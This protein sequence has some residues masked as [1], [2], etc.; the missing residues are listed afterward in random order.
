MSN[1]TFNQEDKKP[2][3]Y[4]KEV[5]AAKK[6]DKSSTDSL[7][8]SLRSDML[9]TSSTSPAEKSVIQR[10]NLKYV[11]GILLT[12][13][14]IV[15]VWFL[16]GGPGR[17]ILEHNLVLLVHTDT[18]PTQTVAPVAITPTAMP[19]Q[20][21]KSPFPSPTIRPTNTPTVRIVAS[22]TNPPATL[23]PTSS[24]ACRDALTISLADVGQTFCVQ[25][26]V[27]Q[28]IEAPNGFMVIFDN[29]PGSFYWVAYDLV[30]TQAELNTCYQT[31]GTIKQIGNS[32]ILIFNYHNLPELC[33]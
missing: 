6:Q 29:K 1:K 27:I 25:G 4:N 14:I 12:L 16:L 28:T 9:L 21:T 19:L 17:P 32:P 5:E 18:T 20:P 11:F 31:T 24:S 26:T 2:F 15:L 23:T 22:P 3:D 30:W 10:I 7:I 8:T 13:F 33:P